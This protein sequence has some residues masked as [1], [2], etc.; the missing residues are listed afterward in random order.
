MLSPFFSVII[1]TYNRQASLGRCLDSLSRQTL[2][3]REFEVIVVDDGS[4][5]GTS[6]FLSATSYPFELR[7]IKQENAGPSRA[8]NTGV[9]QARG[10]V[11]ALTEDDVV[12][13]PDW[14]ANARN[15]FDGT[16]I[17]ILE[18]RTVYGGS[19]ND[20][21]RFEP[22]QRLSF[23]PCNLFVKKDVY[24]LLGGYDPGFYDQE[25]HLYFREDADF[26]FRALD[27]GC[28][29][30]IARD[31][32]VEHPAQFSDLG[33]CMRHVRRYGFDPLLYKRYR[34]LF[35]KM[36]EV[37]T[38]AGVNIHRPQ[39]YVALLYAVMVGWAIISL[40][41]AS[42]GSPV[43]GIVGTF[44]C[45]MLF[46]FKYQGWKALALYEIRET[47]GFTLMPALYLSTLIRGCFRFRSFGVLL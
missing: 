29:V 4:T 39:H 31:V 27:R 40:F 26:G 36:I 44:V 23:I 46:R 3:S 15:R 17:D 35:R 45:G 16:A 6:R 38:I 41:V 22:T 13:R 21:R 42:F 47:L 32:V 5:D 11:I 34:A 24:D 8:R 7:Y 43:W 30:V 19:G 20:V 37:K 1:P 9:A 18:G 12:V 2:D 25:S 33:S 14:L 28:R 10:Q